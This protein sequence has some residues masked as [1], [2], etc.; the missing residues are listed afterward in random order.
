M[1]FD[2][3]LQLNRG[4][5]Y[6]YFFIFLFLHYRSPAL[7]HLLP[8]VPPVREDSLPVVSNLSSATDP[9]L[10]PTPTTPPPPAIL[11]PPPQYVPSSL[12]SSSDPVLASTTLVPVPVSSTTATYTRIVL[13]RGSDGLGFSIVGGKGNPQGDLPIF[14]KTVFERGA[15]AQSGRLRP[16]DQ[17]H[18]VD[19]TLLEGKTHQEAVALLK[20]AKGTVVLTI[21][22]WTEVK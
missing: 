13:E 14:V 19:S 7:A 12:P 1:L 11:P 18:A 21:V 4:N 9:P 8:P 3:L 15:A 5:P 10:V 16:G 2:V 22:S 20:N 6:Y 17:I